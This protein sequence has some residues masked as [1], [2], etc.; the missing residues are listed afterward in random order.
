MFKKITTYIICTLFALN[1]IAVEPQEVTSVPQVTTPQPLPPEEINSDIEEN[2]VETVTFQ[3]NV[4]KDD[5]GRFR[6]GLIK[7]SEKESIN[8]DEVFGL[9]MELLDAQ[10][11]NDPSFTFDKENYFSCATDNWA[12][13]DQLSL[14]RILDLDLQKTF[15]K[16]CEKSEQTTLKCIEGVACSLMSGNVKVA[17]YLSKVITGD[18][19]FCKDMKTD[20]GCLGEIFYGIF[21]N[22]TSNIEGIWEITKWIG[23]SIW[24]SSDEED[25]KVLTVNSIENATSETMIVASAQ[26]DGFFKKLMNSDDKFGVLKESLGNLWKGIG[27]LIE[28]G[29]YENFGCA[30]WADEGNRYNPLGE[31]PKCLEPVI[32]FGCATCEQKMNMICGVGGFLGGE[33]IM[34]LLT[35]GAANYIGKAGKAIG[36]NKVLTGGA[37]AGAAASRWLGTKIGDLV[38]VGRIG[39]TGATI[40]RNGK[41]VVIK[42]GNGFKEISPDKLNSILGKTVDIGGKS[43]A[44]VGKGVAA[45]GK[46]AYKIVDT[47]TTPVQWYLRKL[48][49]AFVRGYAG[50]EAVHALRFARLNEVAEPKAR[51][52]LKLQEEMQEM[53]NAGQAI[54]DKKVAQFNKLSN[55]LTKLDAQLRAEKAIANPPTPLVAANNNKIPKAA[56]NRPQT[57]QNIVVKNNATARQNIST[58]QSYTE[59]SEKLSRQRLA[60]KMNE[61]LK[62]DVDI[63]LNNQALKRSEER[64]KLLENDFNYQQKMADKIDTPI[65][66]E[67][68]LAENVKAARVQKAKLEER[69]KTLADRRAKVLDELKDTDVIALKSSNSNMDNF[70]FV[71]R[72]DEAAASSRRALERANTSV[73]KAQDAKAA[74]IAKE[75]NYDKKISDLLA[76]KERN[77]DNIKDLNQQKFAQ[78]AMADK[79]DTPVRPE[80][81]ID[82]LLDEAKSKQAKIESDLRLAIKAKE[83]A[84]PLI[85][86][87]K[88]EANRILKNAKNAQAVAAKQADELAPISSIDNVAPVSLTAKVDDATAALQTVR[89]RARVTR[90]TVL[91]VAA[92]THAQE[93]DERTPA[94]QSTENDDDSSTESNNEETE[95][96]ET[97]Q[98]KE[99]TPPPEDKVLVDTSISAKSDDCKYEIKLKRDK[100]SKNKCVLAMRDKEKEGT[101][102]EFIQIGK[103]DKDGK[104][105]IKK[106]DKKDFF[107]FLRCVSNKD[108]LEKNKDKKVFDDLYNAPW[109]AAKDNEGKEIKLLIHQKSSLAVCS[110]PND[111]QM[112]GPMVMPP[113]MKMDQ[114]PQITP[115]S[116]P[117]LIEY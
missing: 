83:E 69:A 25:E 24:G 107:V 4:C 10:Q 99:K 65:R 38:T 51:E 49:E 81:K 13:E 86:A 77:L 62:V 3:I 63:K 56:G 42:L 59:K 34:A 84:K 108:A 26:P 12:L 85:K 78:D 52:F 67:A 33:V 47:V 48:D 9:Y 19:A 35:G 68:S 15:K 100:D 1:S 17:N 45:V 109:E 96:E 116:A 57:R 54:P 23:S 27:D 102:D 74:I 66:P 21:K 79:I 46:G 98:E 73:K 37:K 32:S 110:K 40:L 92:A 95:K 93:N 61:R 106:S 64:L 88:A 6:K 90:G 55:D 80:Y 30:K 5:K 89:N 29:T 44:A 91:A 7:V 117:A 70:Q 104:I 43:A 97:Q 8:C 82:P 20:S 113:Q 14:A 11:A 39:R 53:K 71:L 72:R 31:K 105:I 103:E 112:Q 115:V 50:K 41:T 75:V 16:E 36:L 60:E 76:Q 22:L 114:A 87:E 58:A 101:K 2:I 18:K 94:T 28:Q 111:N